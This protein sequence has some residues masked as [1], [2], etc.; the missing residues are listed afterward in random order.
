M[1]ENATAYDGIKSPIGL[2]GNVSY[3]VLTKLQVLQIQNF[4]AEQGF[5]EVGFSYLHANCIGPM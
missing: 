4:F 1:I 5:L 3:I 2:N